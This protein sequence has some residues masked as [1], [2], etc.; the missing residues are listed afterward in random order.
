MITDLP[1]GFDRTR[2]I[3]RR[4]KRKRRRK[5]VHPSL[6]IQIDGIVP[7]DVDIFSCYSVIYSFI[8]PG[9]EAR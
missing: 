5:R 4:K 2:K 7:V 8:P 3:N 1:T 9:L 6:M